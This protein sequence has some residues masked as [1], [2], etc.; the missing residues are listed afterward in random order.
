MKRFDPTNHTD[1]DIAWAQARCRE[2][3][4]EVDEL[5][6]SVMGRAKETIA[7]LVIGWVAMLLGLAWTRMFVVGVMFTLAGFGWDALGYKN[8][9]K[10]RQHLDESMVLYRAVTMAYSLVGNEVAKALKTTGAKI[11]KEAKGG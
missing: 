3:E 9:R 7:L 5:Y 6:P 8:K 4:K 10:L 1:V 11:R 2:I